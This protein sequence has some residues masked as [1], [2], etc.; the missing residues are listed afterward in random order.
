MRT[1]SGAKNDCEL[2]VS[3]RLLK[4]TAP[5]L[6]HAQKRLDH[7]P[8][9]WTSPLESA[10]GR[11]E[12]RELRVAEFDLDTSLFPGARQVASITRHYQLKHCDESNQETRHFILSI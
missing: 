6:T 5:V 9:A 4:Q 7:L 3:Q 11:I 2:P 12:Y 10:H 8:V 1:Y